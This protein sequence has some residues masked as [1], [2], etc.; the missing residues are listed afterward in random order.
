M[1]KSIAIV[2]LVVRSLAGV[3]P[4]WQQDLHYRTA[5]RGEVSREL[6]AAWD[7][8]AMRGQPYVL[9]RP[10]SG[11]NVLV[12]IIEAPAGTATPDPFMTYG[13]N[14][15]ELLV[16][17]PDALAKSL[18]GSAF[19]VLGPPANL[20]AGDKSP[21][22]MQA[23]GPASELLYLTRI[24]P[25]GTSYDLG[26][27]QSPV[28]RVFIAV[29]G[30]AS[31]DALRDFYHGVLGLDV[32]EP[33]YWPIG[34]MARAHGLPADTRFPLAVASLPKDFLVELDDYPDSAK[35]RAR[36][37]GALPGG[38]AMVSFTSDRIAGIK[39]RWRHRPVRVWDFPYDGRR[40]VATIG[41]AGEWIEVL[42]TPA[43]P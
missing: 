29:V 13:W 38:M 22:A 11:A 12:R 31:M 26:T 41:P 33:M 30:G 1:L 36:A 25:G 3:E 16:M 17:D 5:V 10:A 14:A 43:G 23:V 42:E 34:V 6:A 35:A 8:P 20:M 40:V 24:I 21:R 37:P 19:R 39:A 27:A 32:G 28:D 4:A 7:A 2:T 9:M 15:A 18:S